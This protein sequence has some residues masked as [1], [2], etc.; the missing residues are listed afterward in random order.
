MTNSS[1]LIGEAAEL[2]GITPKTLRHYEKLGLVTPGRSENGYR[3]YSP[4]QIMRLLRV[5]RLQSLGLSL[6]QIKMILKE[7]N[8]E[9]LFESI[10]ES[11]LDDVVAQIENLEKRRDQ[12][13]DL[14]INGVSS[15]LIQPIELPVKWQQVQDYLESNLN[16]SLWQQEQQ[17]YA[18][19]DSFQS[20]VRLEE[21]LGYLARY[22]SAIYSTPLLDNTW[23]EES[24]PLVQ[25]RIP[26]Q[27]PISMMQEKN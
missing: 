17:F 27:W 25:R 23:H 1:L 15:I 11:L 26:Q 14:L 16:A 20:P 13:E 12:L 10:L 9:Q 18:L 24:W 2:L 6:R 22:W 19:L 21:H 4:E 5:R 7:R 8:N 3:V